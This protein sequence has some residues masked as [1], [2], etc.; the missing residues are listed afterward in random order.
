MTEIG[1]DLFHVGDGG[2][3]AGF[4]RLDRQ[5][6]LDAGAH[7]VAGETFG[8][9]HHDRIGVTVE[10]VAQ[11]VDLGLGASTPCGGVGLV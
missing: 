2:N 7:G 4:Q 11:C 8:V 3:D 1:V 10:H 6:I 5:D 9:G